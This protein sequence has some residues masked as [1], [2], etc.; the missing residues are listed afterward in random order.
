MTARGN[1]SPSIIVRGIVVYHFGTIVNR[2]PRYLKFGVGMM[3]GPPSTFSLYFIRS[4]IIVFLCPVV[5]CACLGG[6]RSRCLFYQRSHTTL[7]HS[8]KRPS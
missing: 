3:H 1:F 4:I 2:Q 7:A 8:A 5:V 6:L